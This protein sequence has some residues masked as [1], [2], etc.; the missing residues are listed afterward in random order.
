MGN[1]YVWLL[2]SSKGCSTGSIMY[3]GKE[4][5]CLAWINDI[6]NAK[7]ETRVKMFHMFTNGMLR[8]IRNTVVNCRL[9]AGSG[10]NKVEK[11]FDAVV[12]STGVQF[13]WK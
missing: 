13:I 11:H 3:C 4:E 5:K 7:R 12:S 10:D 6:D 8:N 2:T 9:T 1:I